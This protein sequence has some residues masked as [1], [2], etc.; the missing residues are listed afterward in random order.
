[1][2]DLLSGEAYVWHGA[3]N[4]VELDPAVM[5]AHMF[6]LRRGQGDPHDFEYSG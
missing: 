6:H 3:H 1:M 4:Y 2:Q 5:P